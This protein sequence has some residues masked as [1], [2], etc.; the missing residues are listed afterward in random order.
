MLAKIVSASQ[1]D[2]SNFVSYV[3]FCYNTC[4]HISTQFSPNFLVFGQDPRWNVDMLLGNA[5]R[6][7]TTLPEHS[8]AL[9]ERLEQAY[10]IV[11]E[12]VHTAAANAR[13][14]YN[15]SVREQLFQEGD[16]VRV[17][18]IQSVR[19]LAKMLQSFYKDIAAIVKRLRDVTYVVRCPSWRSDRVVH[20]DK[21][22]RDAEFET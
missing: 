6:S 22:R 11:R 19:G 4:T 1:K 3:T 10:E 8:Q 5:Q 16:R 14:W 20:V 9:V 15:K 17:Y 7:N 12:H 18:N 21:L 13:T 2:W